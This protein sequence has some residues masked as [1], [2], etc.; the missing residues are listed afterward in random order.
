MKRILFHTTWLLALL[1]GLYF[2]GIRLGKIP[3]L[4]DLFS[5]APVLIEDTPLLIKE[6]REISQLISISALD[7]VVVSQVKPAPAT[8]VKQL[9]RMSSPIPQI[10]TERLVLIVK[11]TV[12]AGTDLDKLQDKN[13]YIEGDS[14]SLTLPPARILNIIVNPSGTETF[15][16]EGEWKQ[17]EVN[18]LKLKAVEAMRRRATEKQVLQKADSHSLQVMHNFLEALGYRRIR[19][20]T[21]TI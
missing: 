1:T 17:E 21:G 15:L 9:I 5:E 16:E 14:I 3:S 19:V 18:A 8:S 2:I 10:A 12:L 7:E 11:G 13:I 6:V 4:K 20:A